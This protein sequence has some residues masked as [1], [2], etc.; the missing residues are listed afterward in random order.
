MSIFKAC[1]IRGRFGTELTED[2]AR[3]LAH[4]LALRQG[5][6]AVVVAGDV[7]GSTPVLKQALME[8][9]VDCGIHVV[10]LGA[11]PTPAFYF[12]RRKLGIGIGVMVTASHNPAQD[13]GFKIALGDLPITYAELRGIQSLMEAHVNATSRVHG[14]IEN[15][16]ILDDYVQHVRSVC[17]IRGC[18]RLAMDCCNGMLGPIAPAVA[19]KLGF[20]VVELFSEPDG[21][22]PNHPPNP[23][24]AENVKVLCETV[25][26]SGAAMGIAYDG[27]GD[28]VSFV[29][30][31]GR[32]LDNDR[33]IVLF[34][35]ASLA[36]HPHARIVFDQKCSDVVREEIVKA[37]GFP[38]MEKSGY[39][40]IKTT[41]LRSGAPYAGE[42]S[43][44]H[45][46][47]DIGGDDALVASLRMAEI[48]QDSGFRFSELADS[49]P[50]YCT[51]PDIRITVKPHEGEGII[52]MLADGLRSMA[53][54]TEID[55]V[56]ARF[57]DGWVLARLS[58]TEPA[59]TLRFEGRTPEALNHIKAAVARIVPQLEGKI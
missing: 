13:N 53:Q 36:K 2:H 55:G 11:I 16:D 6:S 22:F 21:T 54:I 28:R 57:P 51:T 30:E 24:V 39:T 41:L 52:A 37:H 43:G 29:D 56:R 9:L 40:Y 3:G 44:H 49:I 14:A 33:V 12:A 42:L 46:F 47:A 5:P 25:R 8:S 34:A 23:A 27:D 58:V 7:R 32:P 26:S 19:R 45:F 31:N 20:D 35:R 10:D 38:H 18:I 50:R 4:A 48:L 59:I 17:P 1:D 15:V